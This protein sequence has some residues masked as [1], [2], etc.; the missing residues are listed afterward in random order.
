MT[1]ELSRRLGTALGKK[2]VTTEER[3]AVVDAADSAETWDDL[4]PA[5]RQLVTEIEA[6][7]NLYPTAT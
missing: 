6:R 4:P 3:S 7:P 5:V 2:H 1:P